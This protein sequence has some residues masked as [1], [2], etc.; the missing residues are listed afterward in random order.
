MIYPFDIQEVKGD[1]D[2]KTQYLGLV[3]FFNKPET[4]DKTWK[5][6]ISV[7]KLKLFRDNYIL[8]DGSQA[9]LK[10]K[11]RLKICSSNKNKQKKH[12]KSIKKGAAGEKSS[13]DHVGVAR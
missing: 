6:L 3:F 2:N 11:N 9:Q 13:A 4:N 7:N 12:K 5:I 10:A 1:I 8:I